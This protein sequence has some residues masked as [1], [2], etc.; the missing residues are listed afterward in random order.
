M[1][2]IQPIPQRTPDPAS[3]E[4]AQVLGLHTRVT[5]GRTKKPSDWEGDVQRGGTVP[6]EDSGTQV[7]S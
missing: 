7:S 6:G 3:K 2:A 4:A 1:P 5:Q